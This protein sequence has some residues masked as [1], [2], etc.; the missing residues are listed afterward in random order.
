MGWIKDAV[1]NLKLREFS[2]KGTLNENYIALNAIRNDFSVF[3]TNLI[4]VNHNASANSLSR[5][6]KNEDILIKITELLF[7]PLVI[8][9]YMDIDIN[10]FY[11]TYIKLRKMAALIPSHV[12]KHFSNT[13]DVVSE[14][15]QEHWDEFKIKEKYIEIIKNQ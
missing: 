12:S 13:L 3:E 2:R 15:I 4:N 7:S 11:R 8:Q 14:G 10:D 1:K 6:K 9:T 5:G